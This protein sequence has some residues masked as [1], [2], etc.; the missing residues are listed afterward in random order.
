MAEKLTRTASGTRHLGWARKVL[1]CAQAHLKH[2]YLLTPEQQAA[3]AAEV[4]TLESLVT[5]L[6]SAVTPYRAFVEE[7]YL[8]LHAAQTVA[9]YLCDEAQ[10]DANGRLSPRRTEIDAFL[11]PQGGFAAILSKK[12][13]SR[14]LRAGRKA[15]ESMARNAGNLVSSIP[16]NILPTKDIAG[17]LLKAADLFKGFLDQ[18]EK[19]VDPQRTPLKLAVNTAVYNLRE[20]LD[21]MDGRLRSHFSEAFIDSLYPEAEEGRDRRRRGGRRGRGH[22]RRDRRSSD[23]PAGHQHPGRPAKQRRPANPAGLKTSPLK[24]R[25]P[26][27]ALGSTPSAAPS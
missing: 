18:E 4:K 12:P 21:Q 17:A 8:D 15:T 19:V 1:A 14:V 6:Q 5:A 13:L 11:K 7:A 2:N 9:D 3:L 10:K 27:R 23:R 16:A 25:R 22:H 20:G 24:P 26:R